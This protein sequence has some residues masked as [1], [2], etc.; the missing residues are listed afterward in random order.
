MR[1]LEERERKVSYGF[2]VPEVT[3]R[4][5]GY[6]ASWRSCGGGEREEEATVEG[7]SETGGITEERNKWKTSWICWASSLHQ[8]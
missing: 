2:W 7:T 3:R 6:D 8:N 5:S 1:M 4:G